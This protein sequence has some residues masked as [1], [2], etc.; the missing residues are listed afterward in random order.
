MML[1]ASFP[2]YGTWT[3]LV[4]ITS[5][6]VLLS[7]VSMERFSF[8]VQLN[9]LTVSIQMGDSTSTAVDGLAYTYIG[10]ELA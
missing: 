2:D 8:I 6:A 5:V 10:S 7:L 4:S 3:V 9:S 1:S